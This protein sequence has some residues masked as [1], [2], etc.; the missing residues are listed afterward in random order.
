MAVHPL[1]SA[2]HRRLGEPLPHQL[3][4]APQAHPQATDCSVFP[5][6]I[7]RPNRVSGLSI[8]FRML[9]RSWGQVAY[10]LLTRPP[11]TSSG[12][13]SIRDPLDLHVLGTPP[14]FVLSQDQTLHERSFHGRASRGSPESESLQRIEP[15]RLIHCWFAFRRPKS[16]SDVFVSYAQCSVFKEQSVLLVRSVPEARSLSYLIRRRLATLNFYQIRYFSRI[17]DFA[18]SVVIRPSRG[19]N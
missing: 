1:R 8:R 13:S 12:A 2:T 15:L 18:N 10:V 11:L 19:R 14:A 5:D 16:S 3:A 17:F 4:N 9:S 7:M 6:P